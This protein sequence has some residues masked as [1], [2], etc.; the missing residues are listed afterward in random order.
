MEIIEAIKSVASTITAVL[1]VLAIGYGIILWFQKQ[2]K[3]SDDIADLKEQHKNDIADLK[4]Q[5]RKDIEELRKYHDKDI[6]DI[7]KEESEALKDIKEELC[8]LSYGM[9]AAL[10]GLQQLNCNGDVTK[11]YESLEKH[12]NQQAHDQ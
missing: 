9:L 6:A 3:Q 5:H 4:E 8:L 10:N 2:G 1:A 7:R 11:A 12:L